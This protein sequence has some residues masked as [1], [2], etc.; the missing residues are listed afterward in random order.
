MPDALIHLDGRLGGPPEIRYTQ[1]GRAVCSA[2]VA[3]GRSRKDDQTGQWEDLS[4]T[5]YRVTWWGE[6][7]EAVSQMG[8]EKGQQVIVDGSFEVK[9]YTAKDGSEGTEHAVN[10]SGIRAV[11]KRDRAQ[12]QQSQPQGSGTGWT[13]QQG[14]HGG[15]ADDDYSS[16]PF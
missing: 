13:D 7:A 4:N 12:G 3:C 11:P 1:G 15:G 5:W 2:S 14:G 16:P 6:L 8:L 9:A 10:A